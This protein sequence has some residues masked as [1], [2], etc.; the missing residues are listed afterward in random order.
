MN[1]SPN[2]T[3][4]F[5][6]RCSLSVEQNHDFKKHIGEGNKQKLLILKIVNEWNKLKKTQNKINKIK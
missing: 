6:R 2:T 3:V 1:A 4:T 5:I